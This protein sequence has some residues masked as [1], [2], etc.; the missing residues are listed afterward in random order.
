MVE[1]K[2]PGS[3][4]EIESIASSNLLPAED[5]GELDGFRRTGGGEASIGKWRETAGSAFELALD[6]GQFR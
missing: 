5:K 4:G 1:G 3:G 6:L 2:A